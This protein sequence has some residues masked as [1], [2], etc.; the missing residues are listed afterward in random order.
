ML[1][2]GRE[3]LR[4]APWLGFFPGFAILITVLA[5]NVFGDGLRDALDPRLR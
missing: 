5:F 3:Y 1:T 2:S 4:D